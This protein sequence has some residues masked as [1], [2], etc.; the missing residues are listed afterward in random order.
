MKLTQFACLF[1]PTCNY[2]LYDV[3]LT[4]CELFDSEK[5][6]CDLLRGPP[7]PDYNDCQSGATTTPQPTTTT[8]TES[9]ETT[10]KEY[11]Y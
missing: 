4:D 1:V 2:F 3:D 8:T 9:E 5:R 7:K 10:F 11:D 6:D